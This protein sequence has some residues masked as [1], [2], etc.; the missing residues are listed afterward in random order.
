MPDAERAQRIDHRVGERRHRGGATRLAHAFHAERIVDARQ[1]RILHADFPHQP[2]ARHAVVHEAAG[3][4]LAG[5]AVVDHL[6]AENL[7]GAL[8]HRAVHLALDDGVVDDVAAVVHRVIGDDLGHAGVGVDLH[9]CDVAAVGESGEEGALA[10][11]RERFFLRELDQADLLLRATHREHAL[12]VIH[13]RGLRLELLGGKRLAVLD[14]LQRGELARAAGADGGARAARMVADQRLHALPDAHVLRA[15][16]ELVGD[17]LAERRLVALPLRLRHREHVDRAGRSGHDLDL[18]LGIEARAGVLDH[19]RDA[20][21]AQLAGLRGFLPARGKTFPVRELHRPFQHVVKVGRLVGRAGGRLVGKRVFWNEVAPAQFRRVDLQL[22]RGLVHQA[23]HHVRHV[24]AAGAAVG[25]D[26][27]SVGEGEPEAAVERRDAVDAGHAGGRVARVARA[28]GRREVAAHVGD[29]V[30]AQAEE[31]PVAVERELAGHGVAAAV[32]VAHE[33]FRARGNPAHR[34]AEVFRRQHLHAVL[35]VGGA[36][37]AEAA[38]DVLRVHDEPVFRQAGDGGQ[39]LAHHVDALDADV[40]V[41]EVFLRVV[42]HGAAAQLHRVRRDPRHLEFQLRHVRGLGERRVHGLL[43]AG[44]VVEGQVAGR[45]LVQLRR[46]G[47]E[48]LLGRDHVRQV[49]VLDLHQLGRVL[50][51]LRRLRHHHRQRVADVAHL[52]RRQHRPGRLDDVIAAAP[53]EIH[54]HEILGVAG[55]DRV[56]AGVDALHAR[57][58]RGFRGV[59]RNDLC[60]RAVRAHERGVEAPGQVP[61]GGVLAGA[62]DQPRVLDPA[63]EMVCVRVAHDCLPGKSACQN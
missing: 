37:L 31:F 11:H 23:L 35:G 8:R 19:G 36:S 21:A 51:R 48:R 15:D 52:A 59:D 55:G 39:L 2:R 17:D 32:G 50:R 27:N 12:R 57:V 33:A 34:P 62:G 38:A 7:A 54:D 26:R 29:P 9:F 47:R 41:I 28:A 43:A 1:R 45:F 58:R 6:L 5:A 3:E 46:A 22:G 10:H 53:G 42:A 16:T 18:V 49:A 44:L 24:G 14:Q 56:G 30:E 60:V 13:L 4:K 25:G 20:E 61:V 40:H 63:A